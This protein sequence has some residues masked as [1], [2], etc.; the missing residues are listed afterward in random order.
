[1]AKPSSTS[2]SRTLPW[3]LIGALVLIGG[4]EGGLRIL[5]PDGEVHYALAP[6][7]YTFF[8][9]HLVLD[10]SADVIVLG[11]SRAREGVAMPKLQAAVG[12]S[13]TA[14]NYA[15]GGSRASEVL[16]TV[17]HLLRAV[18]RPR[19]AL[20]GIEPRLLLDDRGSLAS[21]QHFLTYLDWRRLRRERGGAP[22]A[23]YFGAAV[24]HSLG[25]YV[26]LLRYDHVFRQARKRAPTSR[27][28]RIRDRLLQAPE[29]VPSP[30][31]G[32]LTPWQKDKP[33]QSRK[34]S[35]EDTRDYVQR[36]GRG[37]PYAQDEDQRRRLR[38]AVRLLREGGV[39]IVL[40]EMPISPALE[41]EL[42]PGTIDRLHAV[43]EE[44]SRDLEV[45][46]WTADA[47]GIELKR[48]DW[49][50]HSHLN[51]RGAN[52]VSD[53]LVEHIVAPWAAD[54]TP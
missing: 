48:K 37:S 11:S 13:M 12:P 19:L 41:R 10:G 17:H 39:D 7:E 36:V 54:R 21:Q 1:M 14:G 45:S 6:Q 15:L 31:R 9:R 4:F 28:R 51:L 33:R 3:A 40:F 49:R 29:D 22:L 8:A 43:M 42:P 46:W 30:L 26:W 53:A 23:P 34:L 38:E 27:W 44:F 25:R 18:P 2:S 5:Q 24:R 20:L 32:Q 47:L 16:L 52:K 50:E 35:R